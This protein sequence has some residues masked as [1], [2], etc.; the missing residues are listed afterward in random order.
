MQW[1]ID[2]EAAAF[3]AY[4]GLTGNMAT[5]VGFIAHNTIMAG[6]SP[7]GVLDDCRGGLEL[8]CPKQA[9]HLGYL[10]GNKVCP[11]EYVPQLVHSMWV[12]G[13]EYWDF[14]SFDPRFPPELQVFYARVERDEK[15]IAEYEAK[16]LAFLAEV[17]TEVSSLKGW[18]VVA[19]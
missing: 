17:D 4:E 18:K 11:P 16:A 7:D 6:C 9:T 3:S 14:M 2:H 8:K 10:R 5:R 1:G 19:A 15:A 13:A 12:T